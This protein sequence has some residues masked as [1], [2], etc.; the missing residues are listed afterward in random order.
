MRI[1]PE[2]K[3]VKIMIFPEQLGLGALPSSGAWFG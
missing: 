1:T 2:G 3:A